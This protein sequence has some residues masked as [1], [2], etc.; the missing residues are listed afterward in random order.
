MTHNVSAMWVAAGCHDAVY[1][2]DGMKAKDLVPFLER[3]VLEMEK[4][5]EDFKKLHAGNKGWGTYEQALPWLVTLL[6]ACR[7]APEAIVRISK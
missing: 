1:M 3:G 5:P 6:S 2:S 7:A 4:R